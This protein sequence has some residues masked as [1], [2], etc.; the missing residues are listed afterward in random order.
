MRIS[1]CRL[2]SNEIRNPQSP[3]RN[4]FSWLSDQTRA[5][6]GDAGWLARTHREDLTPSSIHGW[7]V[8]RISVVT[9]E[10]SSW[11]RRLVRDHRVYNKQAGQAIAAE[12]EGGSGNGEWGMTEGSCWAFDIRHSSFDIFLRGRSSRLAGTIPTQTNP[13]VTAM[14]GVDL[15]AP[16]TGLTTRAFIS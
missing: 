9:G 7:A 4:A 16:R 14:L 3:I 10:Q 12:T 11:V 1:D 6:L 15:G 13:L 5:G 2:R 8:R